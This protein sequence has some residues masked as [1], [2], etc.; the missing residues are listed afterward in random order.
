VSTSPEVD[1]VLDRFFDAIERL[2]M[3][4]IEEIYD[5]GVE[6]WHNV[7]MAAINRDQSIDLLRFFT[8]RVR[9]MRYE[10]LERQAWDGGAVQRHIVHGHIGEDP[11]MLHACIVFHVEDGHIMRLFEYLDAASAGAVFDSP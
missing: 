5:P 9:G 7:T 2:D 11:Y 10:I 4:V 6:V 3:A 8:N 1:A